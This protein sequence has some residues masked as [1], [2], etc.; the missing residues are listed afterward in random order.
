[1]VVMNAGLDQ[2][3]EEHEDEEDLSNPDPTFNPPRHQRE[4]HN[5][6][7]TAGVGVLPGL[8]STSASS[9]YYSL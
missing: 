2:L 1:M 8:Y 4:A 3:P 7:P 9:A 5:C 6:R